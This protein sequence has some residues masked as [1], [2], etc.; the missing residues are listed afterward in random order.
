[1]QLLVRTEDEY[2]A[3]GRRLASAGMQKGSKVFPQSEITGA[4]E[5]AGEGFATGGHGQ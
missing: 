4:S 2:V 1:M 5:I 3:I